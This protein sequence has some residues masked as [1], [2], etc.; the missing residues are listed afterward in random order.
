LYTGKGY[1]FCRYDKKGEQYGASSKFLWA[2]AC[3]T[4]F[5]I[6]SMSTHSDTYRSSGAPE[7]GAIDETEAYEMEEEVVE[8]VFEECDVEEEEVVEESNTYD[9]HEE[10]AV[11]EDEY[12]VVVK[13]VVKP[14]SSSSSPSPRSQTKNQ[15]AVNSSNVHYKNESP[16]KEVYAA[17][18]TKSSAT[19]AAPLSNAHD[20]ALK[21]AL[22]KRREQESHTSE[23][24]LSVLSDGSFFKANRETS[25]MF[26]YDDDFS[27]EAGAAPVST[28]E[29]EL[30]WRLD[31]VTSL[32]DWTITVN[33][34]ETREFKTYHVHRNVLAVGKRKSEYFVRYFQS[35]DRLASS[36]SG[37]EIYLEKVAA[38][39]MPELLDYMYST[40]DKLNITTATAIGLRHLAQFFGIRPLHL[41]VM[42]FILADL[43]MDNVDI[44]YRDSV[45]VDDDKV[46][47]MAAKQCAKNILQIQ[48]NRNGS[49]LLNNVDAHF[50]RRIMS[51]PE[52][53]SKEKHYHISA[54]L[55]EFVMSNKQHLDEQD[56]VRLTDEQ[57]LKY[58]EHQAALTLLEVEADLGLAVVDEQA[59]LLTT[60]LQKRCVRDLTLNWQAL[61]KMKQENVLRV[62]RKLPS[63]VVSELLVKSLSQARKTMENN[64]SNNHN[65][66][67]RRNSNLL[68][69]TP[70]SPKP[71]GGGGGGAPPMSPK[72]MRRSESLRDVIGS[73][74]S[75]KSPR[76]LRKFVRQASAGSVSDGNND[77]KNGDAAA[78][79]EEYESKMEI[80]R[81]EHDRALSKLKKEFEISLLKLRDMVLQKD[82][83]ISKYTKELM[84]FERLPNSHGGKLLSS[85]E[86][87]KPVGLPMLGPRKP[88][89]VIY[90]KKDAGGRF[91]LFYY[92]NE[93]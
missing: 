1:N 44:Y 13:E 46:A 2:D 89:G 90:S 43:S 19:A 80:M 11:Q 34:R 42:E 93:A 23:E 17:S 69:G 24:T 62:F 86:K 12:D 56:F 50:F 85:N 60:A 5:T 74:G 53:D 9:P 38:K 49:S 76:Q 15:R 75:S 27:P 54:L 7:L 28:P 33:N 58:I 63:T 25:L 48:A 87:N 35:H 83:D 37:T 84:K 4:I 14:S 3:T 61:S 64:S 66:G 88:E 6:I 71:G 59:P 52:I 32:S 10:T 36:K 72:P 29:D 40:D 16:V 26:N 30:T 81:R 55:A 91:P 45:S 57:Y 21:A 47:E 51:S 8:E 41:K 73:P 77:S 18:T 82:K 22:A 31:P 65:A 39:V 78:I 79:R 67:S 20:D 70:M 68:T 92:N